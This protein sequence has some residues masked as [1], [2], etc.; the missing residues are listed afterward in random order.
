[1][2]DF[3]N[4]NKHECFKEGNINENNLFPGKKF[5]I[6]FNEK[7]REQFEKYNLKKQKKKKI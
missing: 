1:M 5:F 6:K 4:F 3:K 2:L 7:Y